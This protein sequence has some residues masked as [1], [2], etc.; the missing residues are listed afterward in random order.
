M[1]S[2]G[3]NLP[4]SMAWSQHSLGLSKASDLYHPKDDMTLVDLDCLG[5]VLVKY[6][7]GP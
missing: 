6:G 4:H 7:L 3:A 5:M 2:A 1:T